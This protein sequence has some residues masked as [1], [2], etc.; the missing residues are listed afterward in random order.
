MSDYDNTNSGGLFANRQKNTD[1]QP[2]L[3]GH[4]EVKCP[5]CL[6]VTKHRVAAW[7]RTSK[8]GAPWTSL[9]FSLPLDQPTQAAQSVQEDFDD[10]IPF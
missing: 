5:H 10:R 3:T 9:K 6:A 8:S 4:A 7:E 2:D 1:K